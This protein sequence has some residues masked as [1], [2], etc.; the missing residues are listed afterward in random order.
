[1]LSLYAAGNDLRHGRSPPRKLFTGLP[2]F[3]PANDENLQPLDSRA[4]ATDPVGHQKT[5]RKQRA[6]VGARSDIWQTVY[7]SLGDTNRFH[8]EGRQI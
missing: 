2:Q 3:D 7:A 1:M 4:P 8:A 5:S 6:A